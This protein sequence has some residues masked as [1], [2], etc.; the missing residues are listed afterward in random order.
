MVKLNEQ[1]VSDLLQVVKEQ[2]AVILA[3]LNLSNEQTRPMM[4]ELQDINKVIVEL[5]TQPVHKIERMF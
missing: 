4:E 5:L 3:L 1:D 2:D